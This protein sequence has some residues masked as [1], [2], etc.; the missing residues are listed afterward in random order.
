MNPIY[1]QKLSLQ[2]KMWVSIKQ[3]R[4]DLF[5]LCSQHGWADKSPKRSICASVSHDSLISSPIPDG[6]E[7]HFFRK[8]R[9]PKTSRAFKTALNKTVTGTTEKQAAQPACGRWTSPAPRP[10]GR[11]FKRLCLAGCGMSQTLARASLIENI[12]FSINN[13]S[14]FFIS[15][16]PGKSWHIYSTQ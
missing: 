2:M 14:R 11:R 7:G 9:A 13:T 10:G 12:I 4:V 5:F 1:T 6:Q 8:D 16:L 3:K 15:K